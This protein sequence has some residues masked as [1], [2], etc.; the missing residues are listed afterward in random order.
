MSRALPCVSAVP[1]R[2][3]ESGL[4]SL[5][6][7]REDGAGFR[8]SFCA[9]ADTLQQEQ[10]FLHTAVMAAAQ[11]DGCLQLTEPPAVSRDGAGC[12]LG[13]VPCAAAFRVVLSSPHHQG[14]VHL[15]GHPHSLEIRLWQKGAAALVMSMWHKGLF[16]VTWPFHGL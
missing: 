11:M 16:S 5:C 9:G 3:A 15:H 6:L 10:Q 14:Q 2:R 1:G 13:I 12:G 4:S 7:W 8:S